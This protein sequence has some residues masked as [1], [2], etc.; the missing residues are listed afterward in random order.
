MSNSPSTKKPLASLSLDL[1]NQWSYMKTHGDQ[2]WEQFPT[3]LDVVV[4]RFIQVLDELDTK[5]TVFVVG[6][7]AALEKNHAALRLIPDAGHEIGNHSFHHEPWLHLY[8]P[9]E[10]EAEVARAE[11]AIHTATGERPVGW[12]GPGFSFS[13]SLLSVLAGRGYRYDGSTFPTYL[14][15]LA[16]AYYFLKSDLPKEELRKRSQLF[17]KFAEGFRSLRPYFWKTNRGELLEIPVTT[18]PVFKVPMHASYILY[19]ATYSK[20]LAKLYFKSAML[21][22]R[23]FGIQP[24]LLLHPLDF[25]GGDD[26]S[27][28]AF[29]PAMQVPGAEKMEFMRWVLKTYTQ[30]FEVV[31]MREHAERCRDDIREKRD[32]PNIGQ[33]SMPQPSKA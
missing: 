31:P 8:S 18:F 1:D 14:G 26:V 5:M 9:E 13:K 25:L 20:I 10:I 33:D 2:G 23:A 6:Q 4:P 3:Y 30:H 15:P 12:R 21:A 22:C 17:G 11:E 32:V 24:S 7:D 29:F 27:E 16:R 28:L 19:F